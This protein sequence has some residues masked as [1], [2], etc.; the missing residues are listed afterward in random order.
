[1][2]KLIAISVM[3]ALVA[4]AA[5]AETSVGGGVFVGGAFLKGTNENNTHPTTD[6]IGNDRWNTALKVTFTEGDA[7]GRIRILGDNA[8]K[9]D[10]FDEWF[11]WWRPIPQLK[12]QIGVNKDGDFGTA[13][14]SGWGFT[15]EN[16]N[17]GGNGGA[18][19][20]YNGYNEGRNHSRTTGW[21]GGIDVPSLNISVYPMEGLT[22][23]L[24]FPWSSQAA[25]FT[26]ARFNAQVQYR[27][28]DIGTASL[29]FRSDTGYLE[30]D[31]DKWWVSEQTGTPKVFLSFYLTAIENMGVDLG[32]AY[33][34][35][36][37]NKRTEVVTNHPFEIGLGFRYNIS[38][39]FSVKLRAAF[40]LGASSKPSEG[41]A[42]KGENG[43]S[44]SI[45]PSYKINTVTV[46]FYAGMGITN[47]PEY[48]EGDGTQY[49]INES[50]S[51]VAW[52]IN[53]YVFIP[54]GN[55][56]FKVGFQLY[57]DGKK[58]M[59]GDGSGNRDGAIVN[60]AIPFGFYCYF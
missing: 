4:V 57:S 33:Q 28:P 24:A 40:S 5:F 52:F 17:N 14:I 54:A 15:G 18:M 19:A 53:P 2:K 7:G 3:C 50:G 34:F 51:I 38:A 43:I 47:N 36:L 35:P 41:D 25:G 39:D 55:L 9:E 59:A 29:S 48:K 11:G 20:E 21:Y 13:Q 60:W 45:L 12:I 56:R 49:D 37:N 23:N 32:L 58:F 1:M 8:G 46:F 44:F 22:V 31:P 10:I 42:V 16:K 27:I 30:A 26:L 6:G